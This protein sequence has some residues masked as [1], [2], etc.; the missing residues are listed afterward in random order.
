[1][2]KYLLLFLFLCLNSHAKTLQLVTG[3]FPPYVG[4][5]F[6]KG[7]ITSEIVTSVFAQLGEQVHIDFKPWQR[8][9]LETLHGLYLATFPYTK[10]KERE[11]TL[12]FSDPMYNLKESFFTLSSAHINYQTITDLTNLIICKPLGYNLFGLKALRDNNIIHLAQPKSMRHCFKMLKLGRVD[13]VMTSKVIAQLLINE[14]FAD[15]NDVT[16]LEK[17][18][19]KTA[20]YLV[21]PKTNPQGKQIIAS[22]NTALAKL[23]AEGF[24]DLIQAK[25]IKSE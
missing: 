6:E 8:G 21:I 3:D 14:I 22:F 13:I 4:S 1:M 7:G 23:K 10:N 16:M 15:K 5:E 12:Y 25:Y 2:K 11:Q 19:T 17:S 18:F 24:I 9:Y 20:H